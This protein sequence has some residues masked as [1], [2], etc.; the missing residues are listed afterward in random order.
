MR[1]LV[2]FS[3]VSFL[4]GIMNFVFVANVCA[5]NGSFKNYSVNDGLA[6]SQVFAIEEGADGYLWIGTRGGG[7]CKYDGV[8]FE[9]C[10]KT[11]GLPSNYINAFCR[12]NTGSLWIGT[13]AG[14]SVKTKGDIFK[15]NFPGLKKGLVITS[16]LESSSSDLWIGTSTG[17]YVKRDSL[18]EKISLSDYKT[19]IQVTCIIEGENSETWIGSNVGLFVIRPGKKIEK[20]TYKNGLTGTYVYSL[21]IDNN[22]ALWIGT[23]GQ[24]ITIFKDGKFKKLRSVHHKINYQILKDSKGEIWVAT[25]DKGLARWNKGDSTF[26]YFTVNEG[27]ANNHVRCIKEDSWGNLW[28]G[29]SGGGISKFS[30]Q[31]FKSYSSS[32]SGITSNYIFAVTAQN[33]SNVWVSTSGL[34]VDKINPE[35]TT[36]YGSDSGFADVKVKT[37]LKS[38]AGSVW[39]GT[40]GYGVFMYR[41]GKFEF[42]AFNKQLGS[43]WIKGIKEDSKGGM[44]IV[45][46]GGGIFNVDQVTLEKRSKYTVKQGLKSNRILASYA[47][48]SGKLWF[49]YHGGGLGCIKDSIVSNFSVDQQVTVNSIRSITEDHNHNL[50]LGTAGNGVYRVRVSNDS[51]VAEKYS[52]NDKL[53]SDNIY[54][55]D[56]DSNNNLWVGSERGVDKIKLDE[57]GNFLEVQNFGSDEGFIGVETSTNAISVDSLGVVWIGSINGLFRYDNDY[58]ATNPQAPRLRINDVSLFYKSIKGSKVGEGVP[59]NKFTEILVLE[60]EQNHLTFDFKGVLLTKPNKVRYK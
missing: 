3:Q 51:L 36:H 42:P 52:V 11:N 48:A 41:D 1:N 28:I 24:G 60:S 13:S 21:A 37:I 4:I 54:L 32:S 7:L 20:F 57:E 55:L 44:W 14:L 23:Y 45:T 56:V 31:S 5:Q 15:S 34:G 18:F 33:D 10:S 35:G 50:W 58:V 8:E 49:S 53:G 40:E 43:R 2:R 59:V 22:D 25:L 16:L 17:V 12:D 38:K 46:S 19:E 30:G 29:T 9:T 26:Q 47:D 6:Q 27:L 39:F